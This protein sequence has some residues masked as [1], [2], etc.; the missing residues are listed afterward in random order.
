MCLRTCLCITRNAALAC[1]ALSMPSVLNLPCCKLLCIRLTALL[2]PRWMSWS[3]VAGKPCRSLLYSTSLTGKER[4]SR[5]GHTCMHETWNS[6]GKVLNMWTGVEACTWSQTPAQSW[7][8]WSWHRGSRCWS[9]IKLYWCTSSQ[10]RNSHPPCWRS[11]D[12]FHMYP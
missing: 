7:R 6:V 3:V 8:D 10:C 4:R 9:W 5:K 1:S 11:A 12:P 2:T